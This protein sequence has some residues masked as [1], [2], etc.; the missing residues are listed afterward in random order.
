MKTILTLFLLLTTTTFSQ[1]IRISYDVSQ[2][3][4][5]FG[6][7]VDS[8]FVELLETETLFINN[9]S[10]MVKVLD[11]NKKTAIIYENDNV[12]GNLKIKDYR[13]EDGVYFITLDDINILNG[14]QLDTYQIIDTKNRLS[15][16]CWYYSEF[17]ESWLISENIKF[18]NIE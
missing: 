10:E 11:L 14:E 12:V 9:G 13:F 17:D 18:I 6:N 4:F 16:F 8:G 2:T 7:H 5:K 15:S 1:L 3:H